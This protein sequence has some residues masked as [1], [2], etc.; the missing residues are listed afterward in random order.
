MVFL[1]RAGPRGR[2]RLFSAFSLRFEDKLSRPRQAVLFASDPFDGGWIGLEGLR[3]VEQF[4]IFRVELFDFLAD[5]SGLLLRAAHRQHTVRPENILEQQK[6]QAANQEPIQISAKKITHLLDE[7]LP[8][9]ARTSIPHALTQ[10]LASLASFRDAA[11][12]AASV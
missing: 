2:A 7:A 5:F 10:E 8:R 4:L 12:E 11:G 1:R 9:A 3:A 6:C